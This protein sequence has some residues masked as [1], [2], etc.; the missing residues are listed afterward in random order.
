MWLN[1]IIVNHINASVVELTGYELDGD[2]IE[3]IGY[4]QVRV[5]INAMGYCRRFGTS[6]Q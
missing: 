1:H 5:D 4:L 6:G 2:N 3:D